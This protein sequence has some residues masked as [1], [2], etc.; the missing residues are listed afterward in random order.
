MKAPADHPNQARWRSDTP[1]CERR[2]HLNNAGAALVPSV[3]RQAV[4]AHLDLEDE[5]GGYEA[6]EARAAQ[7]NAVGENLGRL[8]GG[9][10][11]NIALSQNST[12]AFAAALAAFDFASAVP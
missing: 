3:V 9:R 6:K 7:L 10:G 2:V 11:R 1:G 12:T 8:L 4:D 5:L